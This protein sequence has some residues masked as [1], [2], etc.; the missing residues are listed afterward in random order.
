V[1]PSLGQENI[2]R[3]IVALLIGFFIVMAFMVIYYSGAGFFSVLALLLNV[4]FIFAAL[5]SYGTVLTLPGIA[6]IVLTIGMAVDA[7]VIIFERVREE[8]RDG[9]SLIMSVADGF[10]NSYSA[11]I[12]ANVTTILTAMVLAYFGLGPIKGFA[13]VLIIGVLSSMFTAV[14]V[15]RVAIEW[16]IAKGKTI[17]LGSAATINGLTGINFD[18]IGARFKAYTVSGILIAAGLV[19]MVVRGFDLGVDFKGGYSYNVTFDNGVKVSAD[20]LRSSLTKVFGGQT[21]VVKSVD[22][23][24]T[25]NIVTSYLINAQE[26]DGVMPEDRVVEALYNGLKGISEQNLT[27]EAFKATD[28]DGTHV[29]SFSKVGPTIADDIMRSALFAGLFALLLIFLYL[30]LRFSRWEYSLGAVGALFHDTLVTL[31]IFSLCHGILPFSMEIDQAFIAAILTVIGYSI[32]DTVVVFDRIREFLH[33]YSK[34]E[35]QQVIN[36]SINTTLSRTLL[37]SLTTLFVVFVLFFFGGS[38]IKGFAFALLVGITVGTYSSIFMAAPLMFDLSKKRGFSA[39]NDA[40]PAGD[41]LRKP[42]SKAAHKA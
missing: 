10:K 23:E 6:G 40:T 21:P 17:K 9:K 12:D 11:I 26:K 31:S 2:D 22:T 32:N 42:F 7:N 30:F 24:N 37:T 14:L 18:W 27:L 15:S 13:V 41:D 33:N 3:S 36:N 16:W 19:S 28:S 39:K 1:G 25:F 29:T 4:V 38:S 8:M 5:A 34:S 20:E 35:P